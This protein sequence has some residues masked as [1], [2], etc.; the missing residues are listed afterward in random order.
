[1]T[2]SAGENESETGFRTHKMSSGGQA[3]R[4][5]QSRYAVSPLRPS[6][7]CC[8]DRAMAAVTGCAFLFLSLITS[9]CLED[10]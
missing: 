5:R 2:V 10:V 6:P 8:K 9:I 3:G 1:M 7:L 4:D